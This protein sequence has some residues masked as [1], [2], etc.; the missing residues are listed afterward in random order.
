MTDIKVEGLKEKEKNNE[1]KQTD[2]GNTN[3]EDGKLEE[4][5]NIENFIA[6]ELYLNG[7]PKDKTNDSRRNDNISKLEKSENTNKKKIEYELF[8]K[9]NIK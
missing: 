1:R 7:T 4:K 8:W 6:T 5:E 9:E 3:D 2:T